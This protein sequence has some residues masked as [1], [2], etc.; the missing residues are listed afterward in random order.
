MYID[1]AAGQMQHVNLVLL[2]AMLMIL[3]VMMVIGLVWYKRWSKSKKVRY[4]D[5]LGN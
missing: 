2:L 5:R 4:N 3:A 1:V